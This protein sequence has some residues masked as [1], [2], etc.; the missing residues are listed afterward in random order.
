MSP[1]WGF[2]PP[3]EDGLEPCWGVNYLANFHLLSMLSPAIRAQPADRDVRIVVATCASYVG[4]DLAALR[5][6]KSPLKDGGEYGGS[7]LALMVF[8]QAFQKHLD[9]YTRPD[10]APCNARVIVVDPGFVR[11]PGMRRWLSA[12]TLWGLAVYLWTWP[13]WWLVLKAP[14]GGAQGFLTACMEA[15][16]GRGK[17]GKLIKEGRERKWMREEALENE[18]MGESL[19]AFSEKQI[20]ALEKEGAVRRAREKK[21]RDQMKKGGIENMGKITEIIEENEMSGNSE[22]VEGPKGA[23]SRRTRDT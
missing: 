1:Q 11:T 8:C 10:K 13:L 18:S 5:D 20:T 19:W 4:G 15:T 21:E 6:S 16:L 22:A 17:G 9:A 12:G 7:K 2:Q 23:G 14:D 3:T